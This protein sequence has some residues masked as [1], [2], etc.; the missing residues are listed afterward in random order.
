M[1]KGVECWCEKEGT[2]SLGTSNNCGQK[3]GGDKEQTCG[4][5]FAMTV[6]RDC[7]RGQ[8]SISDT[9][10]ATRVVQNA[11]NFAKCVP[12]SGSTF[13]S[14]YPWALHLN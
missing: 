4:G 7:V 1:Q 2:A 13:T 5:V 8:T 12:S 9:K 14:V 6:Y 11:Y 3:C 10:R